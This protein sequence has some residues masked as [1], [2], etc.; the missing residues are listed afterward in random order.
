[1]SHISFQQKQAYTLYMKSSN[2]QDAFHLILSTLSCV[3]YFLS[4]IS[5]DTTDVQYAQ[6]EYDSET[7]VV[8]CNFAEGSQALGCHV[9]LNF[10]NNP[11][12]LNI[13]RE[14]ESLIA[15][16][17]IKTQLPPHCYQ[18]RFYVYDWEAD[19][20]VGTLLIPVEMMFDNR[21]SEACETATGTSTPAAPINTG[22][23]SIT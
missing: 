8:T 15:Q 16:Q 1:M 7:V 17:D 11:Q 5:A 20:T 10:S 23:Y 12:V 19:G 4:L 2:A 3:C 9:Q 6:V 22:K 18:L 14:D 21:A 13:S